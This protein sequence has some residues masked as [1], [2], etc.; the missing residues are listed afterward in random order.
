M[1]TWTGDLPS[2][3]FMMHPTTYDPPNHGGDIWVNYIYQPCV[4]THGLGLALGGRQVLANLYAHVQC[5]HLRKGAIVHRGPSNSH[6]ASLGITYR[7][8][9]FIHI[10][11]H[12]ESRPDPQALSPQFG[13]T[14]SSFSRPNLLTCK[15]MRSNFRS[16]VKRIHLPWI[17]GRDVIIQRI[18][19]I[20]PMPRVQAKET[21]SWFVQAD[22]KI[23]LRFL[24]PRM[25][26]RMNKCLGL[27]PNIKPSGWIRLHPTILL[28]QIFKV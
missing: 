5:V 17:N 12:M 15:V 8:R 20:R 24:P 1:S 19:P 26:H 25:P 27:N 28:D 18:S 14:L 7:L 13:P 2:T 4:G 3:W 23:W 10:L 22:P 6:N 16:P 11:G 21:S 9:V